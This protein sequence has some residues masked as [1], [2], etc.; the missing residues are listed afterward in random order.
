MEN[1]IENAIQ[2]LKEIEN[3]CNVHCLEELNYTIEVLEKL[4]KEGIND[5]LNADFSAVAKKG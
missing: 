2:A 5:P 3:Y 1:K 4:E